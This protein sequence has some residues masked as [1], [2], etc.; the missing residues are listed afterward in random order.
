MVE[1]SPNT[2]A[3][4]IC[5]II[6]IILFLGGTKFGLVESN[7]LHTLFWNVAATLGKLT[8]VNLLNRTFIAQRGAK[9]DDVV[10]KYGR[11]M[12]IPSE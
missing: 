9:K 12:A 8:S 7:F 2:R 4:E 11:I 1:T 10:I 6:S 5:F 3:K